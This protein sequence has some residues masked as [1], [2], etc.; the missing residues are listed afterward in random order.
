MEVQAEVL[1]R[2]SGTGS[3]PA[4]LGRMGAGQPVVR[5]RQ[6]DVVVVAI[7]FCVVGPADGQDVV[8]GQGVL[9]EVV[10]ADDSSVPKGKR[11]ASETGTEL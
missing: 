3:P 9:G 1:P 7:S 11:R 10:V 4:S 6:V 2:S 5:H 8:L